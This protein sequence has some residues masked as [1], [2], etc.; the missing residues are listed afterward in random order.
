LIGA[1]VALAAKQR[2]PELKITAIDREEVI[3]HARAQSIVQHGVNSD[4]ERGRL[5]AF[6]Q[7]DLCVLASPLSALEQA[8]PEALSHCRLVT[9]CG[10]TKRSVVTVAQRHAARARFVA[11]HP[12]AGKPTGSLAQADA[13][14]F[15]GRPWIV[16]PAG[17]AADAVAEVEHFIR[18]LGAMPAQMGA[19]DHDKILALTSHVPQLLASTLMALADRA[20]VPACAKGPGF[21]S[22]TRIGGGSAD[23]W[24]D[25]F[26]RNA[27]QVALS[28]D[29]LGAELARVARALRE[30]PP[31]VQVALELLAQARK[32][33]DKG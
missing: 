17:S 30:K 31:S 15:Q 1:S 25:I 24:R 21:D 28:L 33:R 26:E 8:L 27:D 29:Q 23:M 2:W 7:A 12:I 19:D 18:G 16:C 5:A 20:A 22:S 14:L 9:D 11:G 10:S 32:V 13:Q 6:A 3:A 4:D